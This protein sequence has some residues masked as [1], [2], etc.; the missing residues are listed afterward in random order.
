LLF[1]VNGGAFAIGKLLGSPQGGALGGLALWQLALGAIL[2]TVIM[3]VDIYLFAAM[4]QREFL[5]H[6]VFNRFGKTVLVLLCLLVI[7]GWSV[8]AF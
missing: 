5:G 3:G 8:V 2:F 1:A 6:L 7:G 4:M